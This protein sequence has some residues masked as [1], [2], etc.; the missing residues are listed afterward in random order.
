MLRANTRKKYQWEKVLSGAWYFFLR[1]KYHIFY[2]KNKYPIGT[3]SNRYIF[4]YITKKY[5]NIVSGI[6][7]KHIKLVIWLMKFRGGI[8]TKA[9]I[10]GPF[11]KN[12]IRETKQLSTDA[13]RSKAKFVYDQKKIARRFFTLFEQKY[14]NLRSLLSISFPQGIWISKILDI[15]I[16][17][18]REKRRLN[19]TSKVNKF[20]KYLY[21]TFFAAAILDH[22]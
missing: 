4:L 3:F 14:S 9:L 1:K 7:K 16:R 18:V 12:R 13:D 11:K 6:G 2:L 15:Q 10:F 17:E 8:L 19:G 21:K 22:F 5:H 20:L